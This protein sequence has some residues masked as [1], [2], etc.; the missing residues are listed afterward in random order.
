LTGLACV[1][2]LLARWLNEISNNV[3]MNS[4]LV[5]A[6]SVMLVARFF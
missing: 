5:V 1:V 3:F 2:A 6:A 4:L